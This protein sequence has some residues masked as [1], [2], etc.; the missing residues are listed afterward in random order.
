M[1][2]FWSRGRFGYFRNIWTSFVKSGRG[3]EMVI[4][5]RSFL[6]AMKFSTRRRIRARYFVI[7][8]TRVD[9]LLVPIEPIGNWSWS[10]L[11]ISFLFPSS[12]FLERSWPQLVSLLSLEDVWPSPPLLSIT[13]LHHHL[14]PSNFD[15]LTHLS[16]SFILLEAWDRLKLLWALI[17]TCSSFSKLW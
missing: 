15:C 2:Q 5:P 4:S 3:G 6:R 12:F 9:F 14:P 13:F 11:T 8:V 7:S 10:K 1:R 17:F 16:S